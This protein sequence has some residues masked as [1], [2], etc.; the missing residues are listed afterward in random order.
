MQ[1][2]LIAAVIALVGLGVGCARI[3][4]HT[5]RHQTP[6]V[7]Q[8]QSA[9]PR[10]RDELRQRLERLGETEPRTGTEPRGTCYMVEKRPD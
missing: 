5:P 2:L 3:K 7:E 8:A 4:A 6:A 10:G 1:Y 9:E